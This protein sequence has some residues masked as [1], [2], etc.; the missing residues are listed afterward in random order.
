MELP[1]PDHFDLLNAFDQEHY[2]S[3]QKKFFE[4]KNGSFRR[5]TSLVSMLEVLKQFVQK[6]KTNEWIRSLV[7]GI[8]WYDCVLMIN[9]SQLSVLTGYFKSSIC[10]KFMKLGYSTLTGGIVKKFVNYY[11]GTHIYLTQSEW[12]QWIFKLKDSKHEITLTTLLELF[13]NIPNNLTPAPRPQQKSKRFILQPRWEKITSIPLHELPPD[14]E[15]LGSEPDHINFD[16]MKEEFFDLK[17]DI[18]EP[19]LYAI[20]EDYDHLLDDDSRYSTVDIDL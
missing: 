15:E 14:F 6:D 13:K 2:L 18:A 1:K 16:A 8:V 4:M 10:N 20:N 7:A 9:L 3:I 12:K 17:I 19:K 11:F 5:D